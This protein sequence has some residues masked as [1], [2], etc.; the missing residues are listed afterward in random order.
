[1]AVAHGLARSDHARGNHSRSEGHR[2][3]KRCPRLRLDRIHTIDPDARTHHLVVGI[4]SGQRSGRVGKVVTRDV[5][6]TG[7]AEFD[8]AVETLRLH[9][10]GGIGV[11]S[12]RGGQV[13]HEAAHVH[14]V[15]V[16]RQQ[17]HG[18]FPLGRAHSGARQTSIHHEGGRHGPGTGTCLLDERLSVSQRRDADG[19]VLG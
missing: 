19:D 5:Q 13:A 17:F 6:A 14:E 18:A 16:L 8:G 9:V 7:A 15:G 2:W 4:R 11:G 10:G 1:M 12:I 3:A